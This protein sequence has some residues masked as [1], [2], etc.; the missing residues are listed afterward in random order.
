MQQNTVSQIL[1]GRSLFQVS[2][3]VSVQHALERFAQHGVG[4]LAV[5]KEGLLC[6]IL[7]EGDIALRLNGAKPA[8]T[9]VAAVM[10]ADPVTAPAEATLA[11]A[12]VAMN[13]GGVAHLPVTRAGVLIGMISA[14]DL[15]DFDNDTNRASVPLRLT[16]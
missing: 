1:R 8:A 6:G 7:T 15:H 4:A 11:E 5:V 12:A 10:T 9:P 16:A 2:P 14:S 3:D 13:E